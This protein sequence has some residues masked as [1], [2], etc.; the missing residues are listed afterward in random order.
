MDGTLDT[1]FGSNGY[2]VPQRKLT[3]VDL[4]VSSSGTIELVASIEYT[5]SRSFLCLFRIDENGISDIPNGAID[6]FGNQLDLDDTPPSP[7][8][9]LG[10]LP[11]SGGRRLVHCLSAPSLNAEKCLTRLLSDGEPDLQFGD[12]G[13]CRFGFAFGKPLLSRSP[14][15]RA[16]GEAGEFRVP[17]LATPKSVRLKSGRPQQL[18]IYAA[19][20]G[21]GSK[22]ARYSLDRDRKDPTLIRAIHFRGSNNNNF[23][24]PPENFDKSGNLG[25]RDFVPYATG[26][27]VMR[28]RPSRRGTGA[29]ESRF[30]FRTLADSASFSLR[31]QVS[32]PR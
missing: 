4:S 16:G 17:I 21:L 9:I 32:Y 28:I 23:V 12:G 8:T 22:I 20:C 29:Y 11:I 19:E 6:A 26:R 3:P 27:I 2:Y 30:I 7:D 15:N 14:I 5:I 13:V 24:Y 10:V 1:S 25:I 18:L 31:F